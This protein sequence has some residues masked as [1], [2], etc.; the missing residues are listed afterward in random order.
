M[1]KKNWGITLCFLL[2]S[3][4]LPFDAGVN[5][6]EAVGSEIPVKVVSS[7]SDSTKGTTLV[8]S[9]QSHVW[10]WGNSGL[11][12]IGSMYGG[13]FPTRVH[14]YNENGTEMTDRI[15]DIG[16]GN[17]HS[18]ILTES[19]YVW[20]WG[21]NYYGMIGNGTTTASYAPVQVLEEN[22]VDT[23]AVLSHVTRIAVGDNH[24]LALKADGTV[25]AWGNNGDGQLGNGTTE[26]RTKAVQV[27]LDSSTPLSN[28][29][30]IAANEAF[31]MALTHD[32][33][34]YTWGDNYFGKLGLG[35]PLSSYGYSVSYPV[36][37]AGPG[38][39]DHNVTH[40][41]TNSASNSVFYTVSNAVYGWGGN[42]SGQLGN[43][44]YVDYMHG[45]APV[46]A[47]EEI[48]ALRNKS[49]L[50]IVSGEQH[51]LVLT[52]DKKV[53]GMGTDSDGQIVHFSPTY[54][55]NV[56]QVLT[57]VEL[58]STLSD[59]TAIGAGSYSSFAIKSDGTLLAF[60]TNRGSQLGLPMQPIHD[61][62]SDSKD[63]YTTNSY[64]DSDNDQIDDDYPFRAV[65][66]LQ[67]FSLIERGYT[68][69]GI[70][71]NMTGT[72]LPY[73]PLILRD[74]DY[75]VLIAKTDANG[76]FTFSG[77]FPGEYTL[78]LSDSVNSYFPMATPLSLI[79]ESNITTADLTV[80][81]FWIPSS[82]SFMDTNATGN[83]ISGAFTWNRP[84][85]QLPSPEYQIIF[86]DADGTNLGLVGK[87][88]VAADNYDFSYSVNIGNTVVPNSAKYLKM[89]VQSLDPSSPLCSS[90][91]DTGLS[92]LLADLDDGYTPQL[93]EA[94]DVLSFFDLDL[95]AGQ[96][97]GTV[98][99]A[100]IDETSISKYSVYI[101]DALG[102]KIGTSLGGAVTGSVGYN[103]F[104]TSA[105]SAAAKYIE[106]YALN[107]ADQEIAVS[108][109]PLVDSDRTN[110]AAYLVELRKWLDPQMQGWTVKETV[111]FIQNASI[112]ITDDGHFDADD[113]KLLLKLIEPMFIG[114]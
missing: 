18:A 52:S 58:G 61:S 91:C 60:G 103:V 66:P 34:V 11:T 51:T 27:M 49:I 7:S 65:K 36:Q 105:N 10:A 13:P 64:T 29:A 81:S 88:D 9:D 30:E 48:A 108:K 68:V 70:V 38:I 98:Q 39:N 32:G 93:P 47:P 28:V 45:G 23:K 69:S 16:A 5:V 113:V 78:K 76:R 94:V 96:I 104:M 3:S 109:I 55:Q 26:Q 54:D 21:E 56:Y 63:D 107:N 84:M 37:I 22:A 25:W 90:A 15:K 40:I 31:S 97:R 100:P 67:A 6:V 89:V 41:Y 85:S 77:V 79:V 92:L 114:G 35:L 87:L 12:G 86:T 33:K 80:S 53:W 24:N 102:V 20:A 57:P 95:D 17:E 1:G 50:N 43:G 46:S 74:Y 62:N 59:I 4:F 112:D 71:K 73:V 19:G 75:G 111:G 101:L 99:W 83:I 42:T 110:E 44:S 14:F 82:F 2:L 106:V 8:L 72:P